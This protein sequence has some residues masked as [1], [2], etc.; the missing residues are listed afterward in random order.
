MNMRE[1]VAMLFMYL[2]YCMLPE[3][4]MLSMGLSVLIGDFIFCLNDLSLEQAS[5]VYKTG[6]LKLVGNLAIVNPQ[7]IKVMEQNMLTPTLQSVLGCIQDEATYEA[8]VFV[9]GAMIIFGENISGVRVAYPVQLLQGHYLRYS[10]PC[11]H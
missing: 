9:S 5:N 2:A 11:T 6:L 10:R 3:Q 1:Q 4:I 7:M 8:M